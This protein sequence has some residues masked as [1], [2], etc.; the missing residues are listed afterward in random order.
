MPGYYVPKKNRCKDGVCMTRP[1]ISL[2]FATSSSLYTSVKS[3]KAV[4]TTYDENKSS[5]DSIVGKSEGNI[6]KQGSGGNSY[7]GYLARKKGT[8]YCTCNVKK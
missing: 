1:P 8:S 3:A 5:S 4:A 2:L 7:A 6:I